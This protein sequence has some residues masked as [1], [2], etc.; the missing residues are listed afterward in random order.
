MPEAQPG[1]TSA[2]CRFKAA[3]G[4]IPWHFGH[5]GWRA[6]RES[7]A[8]P[9]V[10]R[11]V[12]VIPAHNEA[13]VIQE[14]V[15]WTL[16]AVRPHPVAV[17]A[18][19]CDDLT[20]ERARAG[21][22][23][24]YERKEGRPGKGAAL[25]WLVQA[26]PFAQRGAA[27]PEALLVVDA[28]SRIR[29]GALPMLESRLEEGADAAQGFVFPLPAPHSEGS[30]LASYVEWFSQAWE[31]RLRARLGWPARLRGTGMAFRMAVLRDLA[32]LL[33]TKVEDTE[34]TLLLLARDKRVDFVPD[35]IIEHPTPAPSAGLVR[36]RIRW[37]QGDRELWRLY[38]RDILRLSLT[39]N[40][41][42]WFVLGGLLF[43][44]RA[45]IFLAKVG[46]LLALIPFVASPAPRY[47]LII[48]AASLGL[49]LALF[50][51][52]L[53]FAPAAWRPSLIKALLKAPLWLIIWT[54]AFLLSF[55]QR[56]AWARA[57]D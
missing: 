36:Q 19:R 55:V 15:A 56:D 21:G 29:P 44:P 26:S 41:G 25:A 54:R 18:D 10:M 47:G 48:V 1:Q 51:A 57:R 27:E 37:L 8:R 3:S 43:R 32:P 2:I 4:V 45:L 30:M 46:L 40:P 53:P 14:T 17:I 7:R 24:V 5:V 42:R 9:Q 52:A 35:A 38:W 33:R 12:V 20:A 16:Q 22:A 13:A 49:N 23:S 28:D 50:A 6:H 39:L 34:L 31:A 11:I